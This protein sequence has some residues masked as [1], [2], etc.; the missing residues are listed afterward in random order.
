MQG[1]YKLPGVIGES[2]LKLKEQIGYGFKSVK[3]I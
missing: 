3:L 2:K 1:G